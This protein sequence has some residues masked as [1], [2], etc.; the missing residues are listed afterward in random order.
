[1]KLEF[2]ASVGFIHE[3]LFADVS[4]KPIDPTFKGQTV[5]EELLDP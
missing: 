5:Q 3:E 4:E 2:G 1:M